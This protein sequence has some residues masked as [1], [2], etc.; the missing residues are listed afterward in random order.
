MKSVA[1]HNRLTRLLLKSFTFLLFLG[2]TLS[3]TAQDVDVARQKEGKK[4][5]KSLCASCHKLDKK[6]VGPK[7]GGIESRRENDWLKAWIKN[8]AALRASGDS[9]VIAIYEEYMALQ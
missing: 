7:L 4:L 9:E 3:T 5:F 6:L 2:F 1:L 8:N